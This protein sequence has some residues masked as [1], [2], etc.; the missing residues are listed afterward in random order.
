MFYSIWDLVTL[1]AILY[2]P[3]QLVCYEKISTFVVQSS[4]NQPIFTTYILYAKT[5]IKLDFLLHN[6]ILP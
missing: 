6:D 5:D 3:V 1:V 2:N 4:H